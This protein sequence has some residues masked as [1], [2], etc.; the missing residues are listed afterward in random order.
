MKLT[1]NIVMAVLGLTMLVLSNHGANAS[2]LRKPRRAT[3]DIEIISENN[4]K[5]SAEVSLKRYTLE[6]IKDIPG[7][8]YLTA[9]IESEECDFFTES[10]SDEAAGLILDFD[11]DAIIEYA[12]NAIQRKKIAQFGEQIADGG[13]ARHKKGTL[14]CKSA[15]EMKLSEAISDII[16]LTSSYDACKEE[17]TTELENV[18]AE[19]RR[20]LREAVSGLE[21]RRK[22][23]CICL[24]IIIIII[25]KEN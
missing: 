11:D 12:C 7:D 5:Q 24:I 23:A 17:M 22:L 16:E 8:D 15:Y 13:I 3:E 14:T 20:G 19:S 25:I 1:T 10:L 18:H 9:F 2:T 4:S 6:I 21:V